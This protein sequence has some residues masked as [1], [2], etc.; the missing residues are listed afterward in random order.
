MSPETGEMSP[1]TSEG[2]EGD[3]H[4]WGVSIFRGNSIF[5]RTFTFLYKPW[6]AQNCHSDQCRRP[7]QPSLELIP[8][9]PVS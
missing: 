5:I 2:S 9:R 8:L 7:S 4:W 6:M 3:L 1:E